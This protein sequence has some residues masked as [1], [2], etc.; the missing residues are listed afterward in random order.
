MKNQ[1]CHKSHEKHSKL[2]IS[3]FLNQQIHRLQAQL[4]R[5]LDASVCTDT[6]EVLQAGHNSNHVSSAL[7]AWICF[8][9]NFLEPQ[10]S[11]IP[12]QP[13]FP[14]FVQSHLAFEIG[15]GKVGI[16]LLGVEWHVSHMAEP[17]RNFSLFTPKHSTLPT[18]ALKSSCTMMFPNG[19]EANAVP[20]KPLCF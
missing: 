7:G 17:E 2:C 8:R 15:E 10:L 12:R 3:L 5:K 6:A 19:K 11:A 4:F 9:E 16:Q 20:R 14:G 18:P 1:G 13:V